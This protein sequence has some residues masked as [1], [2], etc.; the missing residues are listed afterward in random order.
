MFKKL[1]KLIIK[2]FLGPFI[3][4]FFVTLLVLVMQFFWLYIDDFVGKGLSIGLIL[5][6]IWYQSATLV[7]LATHMVLQAVLLPAL[8][9]GSGWRWSNWGVAP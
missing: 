6:F 3:A 8:L 5:E 7:P 9:Q 2:A 1:D 4:I